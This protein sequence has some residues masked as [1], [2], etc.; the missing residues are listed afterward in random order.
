MG[1]WNKHKNPRNLKPPAPSPPRHTPP[2]GAV[3]KK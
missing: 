2:K 3:Q 1:T